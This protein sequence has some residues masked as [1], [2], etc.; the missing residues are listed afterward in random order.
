MVR[1]NCQQ[2]NVGIMVPDEYGGKR[3]RCPKCKEINTV[4]KPSQEQAPPATSGDASE[5]R[6][7]G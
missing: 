3:A 4:P 7:A 1:F 5:N 6:G 2:C